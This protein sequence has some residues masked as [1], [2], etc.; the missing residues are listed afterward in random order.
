MLGSYLGPAIDV[1]PAITDR[2]IKA[3]REVVHCSPYCGLKEDEKSNQVNISLSK[4][5]DNSIRET[6][7]PDISPDDFID[8]SL[9]DTPLY[10]MYDDDTTDA[11]VSLA[12]KSK[13]DEIP[14]MATGLEHQVPTL[15]VDDSYVNSSVIL[16]R[17]NTYARGKVIRHKMDAIVNAI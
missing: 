3:N 5:F 16:P 2:I 9:E 10:E 11:E 13:E 4:D 12:D 15:E 17:F 8:V 7:R 14:V 1:G 6:F